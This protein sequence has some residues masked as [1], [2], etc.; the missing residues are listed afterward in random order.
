LA[1]ATDATA[2]STVTVTFGPSGFTYTPKCVKVRVNTD[3]VFNGGF[4]GHPLLG[5]E[6]VGGSYVPASS[7][8]F[9]PVT[10]TG[11]TKTFSM[12]SVGTYPYFCTI[13]G[14]PMGMT[15]AVFVVP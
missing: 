7:G 6:V 1:T 11:T 12:T 4:V 13:H 8:P 2:M 15:G 9:V 10:N 5:G 3:V 14:A